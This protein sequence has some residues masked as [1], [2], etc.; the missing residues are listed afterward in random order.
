MADEEKD[1]KPFSGVRLWADAK[2]SW[3]QV[4]RIAVVVGLIA[5][6]SA[7][8][9]SWLSY[10]V[11][12]QAATQ[13]QADASSAATS[14]SQVESLKSN[15]DATKKDLAETKKD[16]ETTKEELSK[17]N[18]KLAIFGE[19]LYSVSDFLQDEEP[20]QPPEARR[21]FREQRS[22]IREILKPIGQADDLK[23]FVK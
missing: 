19:A 22:K 11:T 15:L 2:L 21:R 3:L 6:G 4:Y 7:S 14:A 18:K 1:E 5:T 20:H 13:A 10:S 17:T 23:A 8:I 12:Q 9:K 16:L